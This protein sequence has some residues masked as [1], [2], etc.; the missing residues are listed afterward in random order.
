M[1]VSRRLYKLSDAALAQRRAA[2]LAARDHAT[3]PK[4]A[5]GKDRSRLNALKT[6]EYA[7][8]LTVKLAR[9]CRRTCPSFYDCLHVASATV[10]PGDRC[11]VHLDDLMDYITAVA[12]ALA[13]GGSP[14]ALRQLAAI[15]LGGNF[16][17]LAEIQQAVL[18]D[19]AMVLEIIKDD[20]KTIER[21]KEHPLLDKLIKLVAALNLTPA[22]WKITPKSLGDSE[23]AGK[24][25]DAASALAEA[26]AA[27]AKAGVDK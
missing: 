13:E 12:S 11:P 3:G 2:S 8:T 4:T 15:R 25:A 18:E 23:S 1:R 19:G 9:P 27:A 22:D 20:K 17:I 6:G 24:A 21:Y 5:E 7:T 26:F 10:R 16:Q 14:D